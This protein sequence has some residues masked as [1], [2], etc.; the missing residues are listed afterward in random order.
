MKQ[1]GIQPRVTPRANRD[2][3]RLSLTA[4]GAAIFHPLGDDQG[5]RPCVHLG[6]RPG[7]KQ[8]RMESQ[9]MFLGTGPVDGTGVD[10][11]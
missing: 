5:Q 7:R 1:P 8:P 10:K 4:L 9:L 2:F 11:T 3:A 6:Q